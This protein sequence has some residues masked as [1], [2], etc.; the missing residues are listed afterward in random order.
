MG[1]VERERIWGQGTELADINR[2]LEKAKTAKT[3]TRKRNEE[4]AMAPGEA[5]RYK[6]GLAEWKAKARAL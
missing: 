1:S 6:E 5:R 3:E 2:E 4:L